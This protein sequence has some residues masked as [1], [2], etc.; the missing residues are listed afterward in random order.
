MKEVNSR[1]RAPLLP[2]ALAC[3]AGLALV[4]CSTEEH[5][6]L[7][8]YVAE[9]KQ[10]PAGRIAPLPEFEM[11]E[12]FTYDVEDLRDPFKPKQEATL[13]AEDKPKGEGPRPDA[14]RHKEA[15]EAFPL[16]SLT[17]IG[18]LTKEDTTWGIIKAPDGL[19]HRVQIGNHIGQNFGEIV[20]ISESEIQLVELAPDGNG[21]WYKREAAIAI[22]E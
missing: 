4:G 6:D 1:Q 9:V 22:Q 7:R 11:Y 12:T 18:L 10:R 21:G 16:D 19:V 14:N 5:S 20:A 2:V 13:K 15:L 17:F 3:L 8:A